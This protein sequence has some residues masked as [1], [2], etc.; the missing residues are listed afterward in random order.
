MRYANQSIIYFKQWLLIEC[1]VQY[2]Y[3]H[4]DKLH[5]NTDKIQVNM[6]I[7]RIQSQERGY[8]A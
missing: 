3:T 2:T 7:Q 1:I 5:K 4:V 8:D 6:A